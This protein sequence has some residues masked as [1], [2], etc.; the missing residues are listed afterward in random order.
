MQTTNTDLEHWGGDTCWT[1]RKKY[2]QQYSCQRCSVKSFVTFRA[3]KYLCKACF[4]VVYPGYCVER[5][6]SDPATIEMC[7]ACY[8]ELQPGGKGKGRGFAA[9]GPA[10]PPGLPVPAAPAYP[11]PPP[12]PAGAAAASTC[13]PQ[14]QARP[15]PAAASMASPA[16]PASPASHASSMHAASANPAS[17]ASSMHAGASD[18]LSQPSPAH[19]ANQATQ[20]LN[21][22]GAAHVQPCAAPSASSEAAMGSQG[23][24]PATDNIWYVACTCEERVKALEDCVK[25]LLSRIEALEQ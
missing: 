13:Q 20:W 11:P 18:G 1:L 21:Q 7:A 9:C 5:Y 25:G 12:V 4:A 8:P 19:H 24:S 23:S 10:T 16:S 3:P 15:A 22:A 6:Q 2:E 14:W 17:P